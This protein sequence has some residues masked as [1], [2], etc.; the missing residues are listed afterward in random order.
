V[1]APFASAA[2]AHAAIHG[3]PDIP[4]V[5]VGSDYLDNTTA[6]AASTVVAVLDEVVLKLLGGER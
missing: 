1:T 6:G 5:V 3:M 4:L 2:R